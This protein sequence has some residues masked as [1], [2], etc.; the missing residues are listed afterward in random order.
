VVAPDANGCWAGGTALVKG[1]PHLLALRYDLA[2][3]LL[4]AH[5]ASCESK[6]ARLCVYGDVAYACGHALQHD[7]SGMHARW[8]A[9]RF[10]GDGKRL[11]EATVKGPG[12]GGGA[13]SIDAGST[14]VSVGGIFETGSLGQGG[15]GPQLGIA[16]LRAEDGQ[17]RWSRWQEQMPNIDMRFAGLSHLLP[18]PREALLVAGT[19]VTTDGV[20]HPLVQRY[21]SSSGTLLWERQY[22]APPGYQNADLITVYNNW[23]GVA[24]TGNHSPYSVNGDLLAA[25]LNGD[26]SPGLAL[27]HGSKGTGGHILGALI[28]DCH[29][30]V[31][32]AAQTNLP[33]GPTL[34]VTKFQPR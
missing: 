34:T 23:L 14:C 25:A 1:V 22:D 18:G 20:S 12:K 7:A 5:T 10:E 13:C 16:N 32:L 29:G 24:L 4:W 31:Y 30:G 6:F 27:A 8:L 15:H 19:R 2:G 33:Q 28:Y 11:W 17:V 9:V 3:H 26:G 21:D